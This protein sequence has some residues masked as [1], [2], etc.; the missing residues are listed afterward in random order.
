M[1]HQIRTEGRSRKNPQEKLSNESDRNLTNPI[2]RWNPN[3]SNV[4]G[5]TQRCNLS[6]TDIVGKTH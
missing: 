1:G 2:K 6:I 3:K 4:Q 5:P